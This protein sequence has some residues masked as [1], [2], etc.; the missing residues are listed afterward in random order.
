MPFSRPPQ[1]TPSGQPD[2]QQWDRRSFLAAS[3][4]LPLA[5]GS[6]RCA[7]LRSQHWLEIPGSGVNVGVQEDLSFQTYDRDGQIIW[8]TSPRKKPLAV[9]T[10]PGGGRRTFPL[11]QATQRTAETL[12]R[13]R[14][15][16]YR[17]RLRDFP[18]ADAEIE[19]L[20]VLDP[21]LDEL[22]VQVRQTG[23]DT[24]I[25][26]IRH[27]YRFEKPTAEGGYLVV[28]HGSG[29]L[30]DARDPQT[31]KPQ[32][33]SSRRSDNV[34]G[35]RYTLPLFG[36]VKDRH[37]IYQI[38]ETHWDCS[39]DV[40]HRPGEYSSLDFHW[41]ASL[42]H[43]SYP[44]RML[45]RFATDLDYVGMA[46]QCR[47]YVQQTG[48]FRTLREKARHTPATDRY[49]KGLEYRWVAWVPGQHRQAFTDLL[50]FRKRQLDINLFFP[51]W[52]SQGYQNTQTPWQAD[53]GWQAFLQTNPVPGGWPALNSVARTAKD[54]GA[55][56]KV[57]INPNTNVEG[58]PLY[59][60]S[61]AP[62]GE[63]GKPDPHRALSPYFGPEAV[64][65][66]R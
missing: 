59:D 35:N 49:L 1:S 4:G 39:V 19:L 57:M 2:N 48:L 64:L 3:A 27:L 30:V 13:G 34:V 58:T 54:E 60:P 62:V 29:Y 5:L 24:R 65:Q 7:T 56:V 16:G 53:A 8:R 6:S 37:T 20:L 10:G 63:D 17:V 38:V 52:P 28:P 9:A 45:I 21:D 14:H 41:L 11:G 33:D 26:E 40:E 32:L 55:L 18:D 44:R 15:R 51:K 36:M 43:L 46:K 12:S 22:L 66:R 42:N 50:Q 31:L 25:R 23:G 47:R 61:V